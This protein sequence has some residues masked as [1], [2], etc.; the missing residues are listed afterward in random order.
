MHKLNFSPKPKAATHSAR[1]GFRENFLIF[2]LPTI[3][4]LQIKWFHSLV[5]SQLTKPWSW[6]APLTSLTAS[7]FCLFPFSACA[8]C[9]C[10][11]RELGTA[12]PSSSISLPY[13]CHTLF[14]SAPLAPWPCKTKTTPTAAVL[15][16]HNHITTLPTN[17]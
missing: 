12:T 14:P 2:F 4:H 13:G 3:Q 17:P 6:G 1:G 9:V 7:L 10:G 16:F 15:R 8:C 11:L 5:I